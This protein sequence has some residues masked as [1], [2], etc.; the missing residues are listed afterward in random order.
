MSW[1]DGVGLALLALSVLA[2]V[3]ASLLLLQIVAAALGGAARSAPGP[4]PARAGTLAVLMPAHDEAAGIEPAI[5]A[6]LAQLLPGD[7]LLVVADNCGD[8]TAAVARAAGAEV[9]ERH[10]GA[11]RGKGYALDHGVRWLEA[12]PPAAVLI[13][14]AD[15]IAAPGALQRLAAT[16]LQ[17]GRPAQGLYLMHA[18]AGARLEMRIAA[19]AWLVRNKL[20]PLGAAVL[21]WPCQLM[22]TGMA[23]PW[24]MLRDAP[25]ASG[26]LVEDMQLG[27]DL[28]RAGTAPLFCPAAGV[29]STF[30]TDRAGAR[31]QR[32]RWEHGHLSTLFTV[33]PRLVGLGLVR[34]RPGLVA[35]ALDL[36]VPPLA[37][38]VLLLAALCAADAAW[39]LAFGDPRPFGIAA[40]ALVLVGA[41]VILAWRREGRALLGGRELLGLPLYVAAKL[42]MYLRLLGRRQVEW[43]RT[44]RDGPGR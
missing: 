31:T 30:P 20:R 1:H 10:D 40:A 2:L 35:M 44:K 38:L 5:R 8:A 28:A 24:P 14:D 22:G 23:F 37:A 7:R 21:G 42:P 43:V 17:S 9:I 34:G 36:M 41:A 12:A 6:A 4:Q 16:C 26:H 25:L 39:W 27:L 29:A 3:P 15:C 33:G 11:R 32:T 13:L 19:F 18:P